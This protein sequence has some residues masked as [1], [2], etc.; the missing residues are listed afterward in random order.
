MGCCFSRPAPP[1]HVYDPN[2]PWTIGPGFHSGEHIAMSNMLRGLERQGH[3]VPIRDINGRPLR[4]IG[5]PV[6]EE[7]LAAA[8]TADPEFW[9]E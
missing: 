6:K 5:R 7:V 4:R 8:V 3:P 9:R 1:H 2:N